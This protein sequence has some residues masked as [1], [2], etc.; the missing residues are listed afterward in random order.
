MRSITRFELKEEDPYS[1]YDRLKLY[2]INPHQ[3][4]IY[5]MHIDMHWGLHRVLFDF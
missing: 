1:G 5:D 2:G 3:M 4:F